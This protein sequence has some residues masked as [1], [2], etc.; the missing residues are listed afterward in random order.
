[1]RRK[2]TSTA[3]ATLLQLRRKGLSGTAVGHMLGRSRDSV[4]GKLRRMGH[5]SKPLT[6]RSY[7]AK[8][9]NELHP[10]ILQGW[11]DTSIVDEVAKLADGQCRYLQPDGKYCRAAAVHGRHYCEAHDA[12]MHKPR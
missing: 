11:G 8:P 9:T 3:I 1:M 4:L 2:W 5:R 12:L 6:R 10:S 7:K